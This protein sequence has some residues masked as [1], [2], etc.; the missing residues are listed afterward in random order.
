MKFLSCHIDAFGC[1]RDFDLTFEE[2]I[3]RI[4][5]QNGFGKTTLG[6]FIRAMLYGF[7]RAARDP[8][9]NGRKK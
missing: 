8:E 1:L 4:Y 9:K 2:G 3:T 6:E 7:P 5:A